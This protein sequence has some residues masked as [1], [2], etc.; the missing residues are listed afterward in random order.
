MLACLLACLLML[1][2][3]LLLPAVLLE[4]TTQ[5]QA[6]A[7]GC[8]MLLWW[9]EKGTPVPPYLECHVQK[10]IDHITDYTCT[11]I[12]AVG[13]SSGK[14]QSTQARVGEA[15]SHW[16]R[17]PGL[18]GQ[19]PFWL[20][21]DRLRGDDGWSRW[22]MPCEWWRATAS[23]RLDKTRTHGERGGMH[24]DRTRDESTRRGEGA[25]QGQL[26]HRIAHAA[27]TIRH[28]EL[29]SPLCSTGQDETK[30]RAFTTQAYYGATR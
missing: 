21:Q 26:I 25:R 10:H 15:D 9:D 18:L 5:N 3:L 7:L 4:Y 14:I 22:G 8:C 27:A 23:E 16:P 19:L 17:F 6:Q 1:P 13:A 29:S 12:E 11:K 20:D 24:R 30:P 28:P 2:L